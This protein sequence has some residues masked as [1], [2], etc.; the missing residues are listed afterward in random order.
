VLAHIQSYGDRIKREMQWVGTKGSSLRLEG[1]QIDLLESSEVPGL[2]MEYMCHIQSYGNRGW[3]PAGTFCGT[4]GQALRLEGF[5]IR[6]AGTAAAQYDVVYYCHVPG[7][8]DRGPYKNGSY[9]GTKGESRRVEAM[10]VY[11]VKK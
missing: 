1:F 5:A 8:G 9:C 4:R 11:V 6:L 10:Y 7:Y 3:Y 2:Q